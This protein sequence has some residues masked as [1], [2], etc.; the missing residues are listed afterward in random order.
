MIVLKLIPSAVLCGDSVRGRLADG[1]TGGEA[2]PHERADT[3]TERHCGDHDTNTTQPPGSR[4]YS[5]GMS[6]VG[7][8]A[9]AVN[10]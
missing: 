9:P 2:V 3:E 7:S 1:A 4:S 10:N 5:A 6:A 8:H